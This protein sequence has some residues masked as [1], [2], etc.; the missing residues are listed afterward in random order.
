VRTGCPRRSR[1]IPL[2]ASDCGNAEILLPVVPLGIGPH[3]GTREQSALV[4][5]PSLAHMEPE[6]SPRAA[7][8]ALA[9]ELLADIELARLGGPDVIRRASRLARLVDDEEASSW[10][11]FEVTGYPEKTFD[12]PAA[13]AARRSGRAVVKDG[14]ERF[15]TESVGWLEERVQT[16]EAGVKA[17]ADPGV[18]ISSANPHQY[19][20]APTGN[21]AERQALMSEIARV[22]RVRDRV[23][24][25]VHAYVAD[26]YHELRFGAAVQSA[27]EV[28]RAEVDSRIATLVPEAPSKLAAAFESATSRNPEHWANAASTCRRLL[29]AAADA[30]RPPGPPVK[31]REMTD[32]HYINRLVDWISQASDSSTARDMVVSDLEFLGRRLDA[33]VDAGHKGAHDEVSQFDASRFVTGTYLLLGDVLQLQAGS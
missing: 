19:V 32:A 18:S 33:A 14:T 6:Q 5:G 1:S 21:K 4:G 13:E 2:Y 28:V 10:L 11:R 17:A 29:K 16:L 20:S 22:V 25:A 9:D 3:R 27:F 8:L 30:L 15:W 31:G 23:I 7:A 12:L 24:G 26:R